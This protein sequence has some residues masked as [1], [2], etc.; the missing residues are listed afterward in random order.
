MATNKQF[1]II[2]LKTSFLLGVCCDCLVVYVVE[3]VASP[4]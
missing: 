4:A 2:R 1:V 3:I